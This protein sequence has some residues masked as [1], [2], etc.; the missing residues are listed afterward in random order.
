MSLRNTPFAYG[1]VTKFFHWT[2]FLLVF[3]ML[4]FGFLLDDIPKDYQGVAY[5]LHKLTGLTILLLMVL[6]LFWALVNPKPE[7]DN[8]KPWERYVERLVHQLLYVAIIV[9]P[10]AGWIGASSSGRGPH[11]GSLYLGLPIPKDKA[12]ITTC[13]QLHGIFA[14]VIIGLVTLHVFAAFYHHLVR[15]DG[16]LLRMMPNVGDR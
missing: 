5:N 4:I 14:F 9:M 15:K 6:R 11:L 13:F 1:T 16:V 8:I 2:I 12:L 3:F 10:L 7:L